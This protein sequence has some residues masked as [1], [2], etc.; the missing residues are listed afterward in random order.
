MQGLRACEGNAC[1]GLRACEGNACKGYG[2]IWRQAGRR[3]QAHSGALRHTQA[4]SS[5]LKR[6]QVHSDA[7][8]GRASPAASV[9]APRPRQRLSPGGAPPQPP[10]RAT[11]SQATGRN[12]AGA[13][14]P[15]PG[16]L[17]RRWPSIPRVRTLTRPGA[18]WR[19]RWRSD[20]WPMR[21]VGAMCAH[22]PSQGAIRGHQRPSEALRGQ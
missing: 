7:L 12:A 15:L 18:A 13:T 14:T 6:T 20:W 3:T 8:R 10:R 4:H 5:A 19:R 17:P 2:G 22:L 16:A 1:K 21:G 9:R 11:R